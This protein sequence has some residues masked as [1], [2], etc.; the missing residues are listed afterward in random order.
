MRNGKYC[1]LLDGQQLGRG[2][3]AFLALASLSRNLSASSE[4][5]LFILKFTSAFPSNQ[6]G[7]CIFRYLLVREVLLAVENAEED[8]SQAG[9]RDAAAGLAAVATSQVNEM[10]TAPSARDCNERQLIPYPRTGETARHVLP[11]PFPATL[12]WYT[13]SVYKK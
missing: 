12:Y 13:W 4:R 2:C 11:P 5:M 1:R 10:K 6:T 3:L 9:E 8:V 7:N